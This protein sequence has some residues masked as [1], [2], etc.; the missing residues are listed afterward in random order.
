MAARLP[1][2]LV[3]IEAV[4]VCLEQARSLEAAADAVRTDDIGLI[5]AM[6]WAVRRR[7]AV[8]ISLLTLKGLL[9]EHFLECAPTMTDFRRR[10]ETDR[11]LEHLREIA[12]AHL[13]VLPPPLGFAPPARRGG[14]RARAHQQQ[15]GPD[16]PRQ[17]R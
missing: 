14:D 17:T 1:G 15:P 2:A 12:A 11:A 7:R 6:R 8:Q 13:H 16:P 3:E 9:P 5:G 10:L 4:V